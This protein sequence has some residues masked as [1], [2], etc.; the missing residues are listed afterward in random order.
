MHG[1]VIDVRSG[2]GTKF[3]IYLPAGPA[4][5]QPA[6]GEVA[7]R[8]SGASDVLIIDNDPVSVDAMT[9]ILA[10]G[11]NTPVVVSS[12]AEGVHMLKSNPGRFNIVILDILMREMDGGHVFQSLKLVR[13]DVKIIICSETV[14]EDQVRRLMR[15]GAFAFLQKPFDKNDFEDLIFSAMQ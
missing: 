11:G 2:V 6:A 9:E 7:T 3:S 10:A 15:K 14:A 5:Q 4:K 8:E 13:P 12:G 1:G